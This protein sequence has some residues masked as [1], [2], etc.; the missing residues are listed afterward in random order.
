MTCN[1]IDCMKRQVEH[2]FN[3]IWHYFDKIV[4]EGPSAQVFVDEGSRISGR[5]LTQIELL[6][7]LRGQGAEPYLQFSYKPRALCEHHLTE[8]AGLAGLKP[9]LDR[10]FR[11]SVVDS[12][13]RRGKLEQLDDHRG[14]VFSHPGSEVS[15][16]ILT[17]ETLT[18]R[19]VAKREF[20]NDI[21]ALLGDVSLANTLQAPLVQEA[22]VYRRIQITPGSES[23]MA[24]V[25]LDLDLPIMKHISIKDLLR[26]RQDHRPELQLFRN[27]L[28]TAIR[29]EIS[30][31]AAGAPHEIASAVIRDHVEPEL[32]RI[33][34]KLRVAKRTFERKT[35]VELAV[36]TVAASVSLIAGAPLVIGGGAA[37]V[38]GTIT[39]HALDVIDDKAEAE[40]S[41]FHFL[42]RARE[43]GRRTDSR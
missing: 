30:N 32:A 13:V 8:S 10:R 17:D 22:A 31:N 33:D 28:R 3:E 27:A 25:A 29:E 26:L 37:V 42:W 18:L 19:Q 5:L 11:R 14:W 12:M 39:R 4:V 34:Q 41:D 24:N 7:W 35:A 38:A 1:H 2:L 43:T 15:T 6:L 23:S 20:Q 40:M 21:V 9:L 36:S 16:L